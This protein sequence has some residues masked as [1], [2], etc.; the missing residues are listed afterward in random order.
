MADIESAQIEI[1]ALADVSKV[2]LSLALHLLWLIHCL[3]HTY[4]PRI[5]LLSRISQLLCLALSEVLRAVRLRYDITEDEW[6]CADDVWCRKYD[7]RLSS[8][9]RC[10]FFPLGSLLD[11]QH[12]RSIQRL[13]QAA[14]IICRRFDKILP[15]I[16][17]FRQHYL[18]LINVAGQFSV[19]FFLPL[20]RSIFD[21]HGPSERVC[22]TED[23]LS[24]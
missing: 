1:T 18:K 13:R 4:G 2:R 23:T 9:Q 8:L 12:F 16:E 22:K 21:F 6:S 11:S 15:I 10:S 3:Q 17:K 24:L 20:I 7:Q 14:G 5:Q 19:S